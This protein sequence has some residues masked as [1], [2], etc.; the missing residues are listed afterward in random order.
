[1]EQLENEIWKPTYVNPYYFVSNKGRVKSIER[2]I[3]CIAN[4]S[5]SIR[6]ERLL[7][8]NNQNSKRYWRIPIPPI[9]GK[10]GDQKLYAVHRLVATA[11]L[12]NPNNLP[13]INH[14][15][16]NKD[17][18]CVENLEWCDNRYNQR[19]AAEHGLKDKSK[20]SAHSSFRKL[21]EEQ[22]EFI[23]AMYPTLNITKRGELERFNKVIQQM[24]GLKS[25]NT[26]RWIT[27]GGTNKFFNQD[28]V[29][30]TKYNEMLDE[31]NRI[32][33]A[34]EPQKTRADWAKELGINYSS[35][36]GRW[37]MFGK[38]LDATINYYRN[39]QNMQ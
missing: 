32:W 2:P 22:V 26:V 37:R 14:I 27:Q 9:G 23:K 20:M 33:K 21:T 8:P 28:I 31:Y 24:F 34:L 5:Y 35:F 39:L 10:K 29:Q 25:P 38:D 15:D 36:T 16:G 19:H 12:P 7:K 17:N 11:F 1:M 30:T 18:N 6:K 3:W 13:Q 4:N